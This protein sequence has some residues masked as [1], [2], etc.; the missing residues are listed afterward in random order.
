MPIFHSQS[1]LDEIAVLLGLAKSAT[2]AEVVFAAKERAEQLTAAQT[3]RDRVKG[4]LAQAENALE[5]AKA[6]LRA[7][8]GLVEELTKKLE[9]QAR[10]GIEARDALDERHL[11]DGVESRR[12]IA[13]AEER[14]RVSQELHDAE[15]ARHAET[16]RQRDAHAKDHAEAAQRVSSLT[17]EL[18]AQ[19][20]RAEAAEAD[21]RA[22]RAQADLEAQ[23]F[24]D[25]I[26]KT[27]S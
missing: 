27:R 18:S 10:H 8:A 26:E 7:K 5:I 12:R 25:H 22:A 17:T 4:K 20:V 3:D 15:A 9:D 13:A 1:S 16:C 21:S 23:A 11:A 6:D 14:L 19:R 2:Y 24:R